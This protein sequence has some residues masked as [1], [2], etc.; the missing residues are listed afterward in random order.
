MSNR[1]TTNIL[2][3]QRKIESV[4]TQLRSLTLELDSEL[5]QLTRATTPRREL[6]VGDRV[7]I[8]S[9]HGGLFGETA[10]ITKLHL[11]NATLVLDKTKKK[12]QRK[13]K[14]LKLLDN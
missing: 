7:T 10:Q 2:R 6:R 1:N 4:T 9:R 8:T 14:N 13:K 5:Q 12:V 11:V 3:L